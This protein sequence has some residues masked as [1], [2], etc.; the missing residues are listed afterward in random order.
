MPRYQFEGKIPTGKVVKG[1]VM[2][3]NPEQVRAK[4]KRNGI[5]VISL[6]PMIIEKKSMF[7]AGISKRDI[8]VFTRQFS[9]MQDSGMGL[10]DTF[11]IL[12][13]QSKKPVLA[14]MIMSLKSTVEE[15][16]TLAEALEKYPKHFNELYTNMVR[17]GEMSGS[18]DKVLERLADYLEKAQKL[19][20]QVKTALIYP[21][22]VISAATIIMWGLLVFVV[23]IFEKVFKQSGKELPLITQLLIKAS[24]I[25]RENML[26][27]FT[28]LIVSGFLIVAY[29]RTPN[30]KYNI[31]Y[32]LLK[33]TNNR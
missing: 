3:S 6:T 15:G 19:V 27:S 5:F 30:G 13:K 29:Y 11:E 22:V 31:E 32:M 14:K 12:A 25:V 2:G 7:S 17:S 21:S 9:V 24:G 18:L 8:V 4:L 26:L 16:A 20:S 28:I 33:N 10:V 23:P 1:T